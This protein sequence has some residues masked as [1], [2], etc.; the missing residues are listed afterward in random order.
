M[1]NRPLTQ[2]ILD[3]LAESAR[4]EPTPAIDFERMQ[5]A[6]RQQWIGR[7]V[8]E[9][10]RPV[11]WHWVSAVAVAVS[12][13]VGGWYG[14]ANHKSSTGLASESHSAM[15]AMD[16]RA[17]A[18]GQELSADREPL[19]VNHPGIA[20]WTLAPEG[21]ARL[22]SKGQYLTVRLDFGRV[23]A[24]VVPS[25]QP[26]SFA[27]EA[28]TMRIAVHG[29]AFTV[30]KQADSVVVAVSKGTV[31]V[32]SLGQPGQTTGT[33]LHAPRTERFAL[34]LS[35][36][37]S[38]SPKRDDSPPGP[39][40][41][42]PKAASTPPAPTTRPPDDELAQTEPQQ[43]DRPSRVEQEA[44]LDAVR[45][46][47]ARCFAQA[48]NNETAH[49]SHVVVRVDTQLTITIAPSGAIADAAFD[50]PVPD[51]ILECTRHEIGDWSAARSKLGSSASRPIMLTR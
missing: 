28:G 5:A 33:V 48:K 36:D 38:P 7:R 43:N 11:R 30:D 17:L 39:V 44:A 46:A 51:A 40:A 15:Q 49:D 14:H 25:A 12:F 27:V 31:V 3:Q 18:V 21:K 16:G 8:T 24:E 19:V 47:A 37:S 29:T 9:R 45:A 6:L 10:H 42:R 4:S 22:A 35:Q 20:R 34:V 13:L 41:S 2:R 1:S 23:D 50:P 26:E 32:G